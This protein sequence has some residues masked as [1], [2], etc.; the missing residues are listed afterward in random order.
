MR[1][2]DGNGGKQ[3]MQ[4]TRLKPTFLSDPYRSDSGMLKLLAGTQDMRV[5]KMHP[6]SVVLIHSVPRRIKGW[7][8]LHFGWGQVH[9][10][11]S[12]IQVFNM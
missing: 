2:R 11:S 5:M 9:L 1:T 6:T 3:M 8:V 7:Q 4:V 10:I 12:V